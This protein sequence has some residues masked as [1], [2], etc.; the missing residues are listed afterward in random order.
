M[1]PQPAITKRGA[2]PPLQPG[3][4]AGDMQEALRRLGALEQQVA[5]LAAAEPAS[6][7][8]ERDRRRGQ[9]QIASTSSNEL[10]R[11]VTASRVIGCGASGSGDGRCVQV[12]MAISGACT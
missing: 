6:Q 10:A 2:P 4:D 7:V 8:Q 11:W 1:T 9:T 5:Q 12:Y 3:V